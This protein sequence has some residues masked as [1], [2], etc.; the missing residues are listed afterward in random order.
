MIHKLNYLSLLNSNY[1]KKQERF[2]DKMCTTLLQKRLVNFP[3]ILDGDHIATQRVVERKVNRRLIPN[4]DWPR[5]V[6]YKNINTPMISKIFILLCINICIYIIK[7]LEF[8][9]LN[10]IVK[11]TINEISITNIN[12]S[13]YHMFTKL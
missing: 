2:S 10:M 1:T 9:L 8:H 11:Q 3:H 5:I 13:N 7:K 4:R 6:V 12:Y